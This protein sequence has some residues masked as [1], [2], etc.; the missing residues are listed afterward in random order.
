MGEVSVNDDR[1][2]ITHLHTNATTDANIWVD[3]VGCSA[4]TGDGIYRA[5]P[6]TDSTARANSIDDLVTDQRFANLGRAP[7]FENVGFIFLSEVF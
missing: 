7:F 5:I 3:H 2:E 4:F 1:I 6:G